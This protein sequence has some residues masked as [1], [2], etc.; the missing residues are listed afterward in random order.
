MP[1]TEYGDAYPSIA[2]LKL[3]GEFA[4]RSPSRDGSIA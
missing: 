1:A 3:T 4:V 2:D